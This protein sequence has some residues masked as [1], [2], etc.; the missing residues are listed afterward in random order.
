[1]VSNN[2]M[3]GGGD[4]YDVFKTNALNAYDYGPNL[5]DVMADFLKARGEYQ[6]ATDDR[7]TKLN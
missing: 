6:P 4:G 2:F 5:E 1:M 3:R 7:I